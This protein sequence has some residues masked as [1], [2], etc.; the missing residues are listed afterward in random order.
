[1][2]PLPHKYSSDTVTAPKKQENCHSRATAAAGQLRHQEPASTSRQQDAGQTQSP[3]LRGSPQ[4]NLPGQAETVFI[5]GTVTWQ[6]QVPGGV[7]SLIHAVR[8]AWP[9]LSRTGQI[10][11]VFAF[12]HTGSG[13]P[14]VSQRWLRWHPAV[15]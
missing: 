2:P 10:G 12:R 13:Q 8:S 15:S 7:D 5:Y 4:N 11:V 9:G 14:A 1:M 6:N 3:G